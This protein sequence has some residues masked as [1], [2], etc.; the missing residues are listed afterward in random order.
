MTLK[1]FLLVVLFVFSFGVGFLSVGNGEVWALEKNDRCSG[2]EDDRCEGGGDPQCIGGP[3]YGYYCVDMDEVRA[4]YERDTAIPEVKIINKAIEPKDGSIPTTIFSTQDATTIG[5]MKTFLTFVIGGPNVV[6]PGSQEAGLVQNGAIGNTGKA[7]ATLMGNPTASGE[8]YIADLMY[9][10]KFLGAPPAYAQVGGLGFSSLEPILEA[11]KQFRNIAYMF[12]III[13]VVIGFMIMMRQKI[14]GQAAVTAQQA[15]PNIVIALLAVTFSYAVAGFLIDFMYLVMYLL[16]GLFPGQVD[17]SY[18]NKNILQLGL[19]IFKHGAISA[20]TAVGEFTSSALEGTGIGN[21]L[22]W[23]TGLTFAVIIAFAY[24]FAVISLFFELLKTYVAII[25]SIVLSP[26]LLMMGALPGRTDVFK[27]WVRSLVGNL[28]AFPVV[29]LLLIIHKLL[30]QGSGAEGG[31]LPPYL[32][33][34]GSAGAITTL[35]G[36]AIMLIAKDLVIQA[37]KAINPKGS[38]IFEQFGSALSSAVSKGW[39]GGELIPG[40]GL[41]DT[42]KY[43]LSGKA[44]TEQVGRKAAIG[45]AVVG[46]GLVGG[47]LGGGG[48]LM[49]RLTGWGSGSIR[50]G[51]V[52]GGMGAGRRLADRLKDRQLFAKERESRQKK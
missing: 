48:R 18:V 49:G 21:Q 37:K 43:G 16:V 5:V 2:P 26:L 46:G 3:P 8:T 28:M 17:I 15:I 32:I 22:G 25:I 4:R 33:G 9:N 24:L 50:G 35:I 20:R 1:R 10:A 38:G 23:I 36:L 40:V 29:L 41:T 47:A 34:R 12:F 13:V 11:W 31:F 39:K 19:G 14:G 42:S 6:D 45:G 44:L 52:S 30:T 7:I 27:G 51:A